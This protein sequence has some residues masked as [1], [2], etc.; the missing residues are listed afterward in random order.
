MRIRVDID[1]HR[2]LNETDTSDL[3][4]I[5]GRAFDIESGEGFLHRITCRKDL[6]S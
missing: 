5:I 4:K 6:K 2:L 3:E 1:L